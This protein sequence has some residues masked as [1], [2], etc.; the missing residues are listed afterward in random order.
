MIKNTAAVLV[1]PIATISPKHSR[2]NR[3]VIAGSVMTA[4]REMQRR[5]LKSA[6]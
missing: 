6:L 2:R 1:D 4:P 5:C 3:P